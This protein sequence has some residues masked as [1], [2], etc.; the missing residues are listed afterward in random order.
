MGNPNKALSARVILQLLVFIVLVPF[1]PLLISWKW[2][3]WR[4]WVYGLV[5]VLQG[6]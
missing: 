1:L 4:A 6:I 3:W 5:G 2:D